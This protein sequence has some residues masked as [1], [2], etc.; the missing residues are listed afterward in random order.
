MVNPISD[1]IGLLAGLDFRAVGVLTLIAAFIAYAVVLRLIGRQ[2]L[3]CP[4]QLRMASVTFRIGPDG[5][6]TD[7]L[8]C[9]LFRGKPA[10]TCG[11][12]CLPPR[13]A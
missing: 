2:R 11:K 13:A 1:A 3:R 6:P 12:V 10:I 4:A 5:R 7:V 8:R 9:S